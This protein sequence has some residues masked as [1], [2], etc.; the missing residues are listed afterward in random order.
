M[1]NISLL[2]LGTPV[3]GDA[4]LISSAN[5]VR[6]A[7]V[8]NGN[9]SIGEAENDGLTE[10]LIGVESLTGFGLGRTH[11]HAM[12]ACLGHHVSVLLGF[13]EHL[14]RFDGQKRILLIA[15]GWNRGLLK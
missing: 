2:L 4:P 5:K 1:V 13:T 15:W 9:G 12:R 6:A 3:N 14:L 10:K 11:P 7:R 8:S